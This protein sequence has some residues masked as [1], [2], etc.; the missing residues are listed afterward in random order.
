MSKNNVNQTIN[1]VKATVEPTENKIAI[2]PTNKVSVDVYNDYKERLT[3][4]YTSVKR[5]AL[6]TAKL[7]TEMDERKVLDYD[8]EGKRYSSLSAFAEEELGIDLSDKQL[9]TYKRIVQNYGLRNEDGTYT[10]EDKFYN[11]GIEKLD[12]IW[13]IPQMNG[14]RTNFDEVVN[15]LGITPNTTALNLKTI[16]STAKGLTTTKDDKPKAKKDEKTD[17]EKT[18]AKANAELAKTNIELE[19][20]KAE[21]E[22]T[23]VDLQ[24]LIIELSEKANSKITDKEFRAY[25]KDTL[26]AIIDK[27]N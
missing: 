18:L 6:D 10:I 5:S 17:A 12:I 19:K 15:A 9:A 2:E 7:F 14:Q 13:R 16:V 23:I 26:K 1:E 25:A 4:I 22:A 3:A 20:A 24:S 11:Y 8:G 21:N 27:M